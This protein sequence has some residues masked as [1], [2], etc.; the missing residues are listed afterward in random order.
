MPTRLIVAYIL[1]FLLV[2]GFAAGLFVVT[3][4]WRAWRRSKRRASRSRRERQAD[5][6]RH[7]EG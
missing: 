2:A 4:E 3:H 6:A 1:I 5:F 7:K